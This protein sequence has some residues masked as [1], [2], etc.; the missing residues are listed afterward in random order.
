MNPPV[1]QTHVSGRRNFSQ[2]TGLAC[3]RVRMCVAFAAIAAI[4][5][6]CSEGNPQGDAATVATPDAGPADAATLK[7]AAPTFTPP[8]GAYATAQ[9]V[10]LATSTPG[11][12]VYFTVD[13]NPP[14]TGSEKYTTP[15]SVP[16]SATPVRISA[17]AVAGGYLD[18]DVSAAT[19][20][21]AVEEARAAK[22]SISPAGGSYTSSQLITITTTEPAGTLLFTTNGTLPTKT[23]GT[24]YTGVFTVSAADSTVTAVTTASNK[25]D[26]LPATAT[27]KI[28][29]AV[30]STAAPS[31][32]PAAGEYTEAQSITMSTASADATI[33]YTVDGNSPACDAAQPIDQMCRGTSVRYINTTPPALDAVKTVKALACKFGSTNSTTTSATYTF[34]AAQPTVTASGIVAF[35]TTVFAHV[36]TPGAVLLYTL[37]TDG[38]TPADPDVAVAGTC[39]PASGVA[40]AGSLPWNIG[41]ALD[42]GITTTGMRRNA[43]FKFRACRVG[44]SASAVVSADYSA[45]LTAKLAAPT[46]ANPPYGTANSTVTPVYD[47]TQTGATTLGADPTVGLVCYTGDGVS[48]PACNATKTA[49]AIG[50]SAVYGG[51][52]VHTGA[53]IANN[54]GARNMRAIACK[55]GATDS[56]VLSGTYAFQLRVAAGLESGTVQSIDA[57]L[58]I[59]L[60]V[61]ETPPSVNWPNPFTV[62]FYYTTDGST[63]LRPPTCGDAATAPTLRTAGVAGQANTA[64]F[65][66]TAS[67]STLK[68]IACAAN[69][70]DS[71][72]TTF[73]YSAP[74]QL[75]APAISPAS[76]TYGHAMDTARAPDLPSGTVPVAPK[77]PKV[78]FA[79]TDVAY[80]HV[81]WTD[82]GSDPECAVATNSCATGASLN[83]ATEAGTAVTSNFGGNPRVIKARTCRPGY[84]QSP[85]ATATYIFQIATPALPAGPALPFGNNYQNNIA[86]N[87]Q[88]GAYVDAT[89]RG[90]IIYN[91]ATTAAGTATFALTDGATSAS[92]PVCGVSPTSLNVTSVPRVVKARACGTGFA[93]SNIA[94]AT[95]TTASVAQPSFSLL[96][97]ATYASPDKNAGGKYHDYFDISIASTTTESAAAAAGVGICYTTDG[98]APACGSFSS[99]NLSCSNGAPIDA[100]AA[101]M[102][103]ATISPNP[104]SGT[105]TVRAVACSSGLNNNVSTERSASYAYVVSALN[106]TA[107]DTGAA[108]NKSRAIA[109]SNDATVT[110]NAGRTQDTGLVL[111][112]SQVATPPLGCTA[113][114]AGA[115]HYCF[116]ARAAGTGVDP[117]YTAWATR[118]GTVYLRAC[119]AGL[120]DATATYTATGIGTYSRTVTDVTATGAA[121][122]Y[123]NAENRFVLATAAADNAQAWVSFDSANLYLTTKALPAAGDNAFNQPTEYGYWYLSGAAPFATAAAAS[124][125]GIPADLPAAAL[126]LVSSAAHGFGSAK[127]VVWYNGND[128]QRGMAQ[129][130]GTGWTVVNGAVFANVASSTGFATIPRSTI[131]SPALLTI[132]GGITGGDMASASNFVPGVGNNSA[133][134]RLVLDLAAG[135]H[136][137]WDKHVCDS[138]PNAG[139]SAWV[140]NDG[141]FVFCL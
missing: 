97:R 60:R 40:A 107:A 56:D 51:G 80:N 110:P 74:G 55:P 64:G 37:K 88:F 139:T 113:A 7:A 21:F 28:T 43:K 70:A 31:F 109:L 138:T 125:G 47:G 23:N 132:L 5:A 24:V 134:R 121:G 39:T 22:P 57:S 104:T 122:Q 4:A 50:A 111:C 131:G 99:A 94:T 79:R 18:S 120:E 102:P 52:Q 106:T 128:S 36:T 76:G 13:G 3:L 25:A 89:H 119:K 29:T 14:T 12:T 130:N 98:T 53:S 20:T 72:S 1:N 116:T 19:Y 27:Y 117:Q 78:Y 87:N 73:T 58:T 90:A 115:N 123:S 34:R 15:I 84:P 126:P 66:H 112:G 83:T 136:P 77:Q 86:G 45:K 38:T 8:G 26:S 93:D 75:T 41:K 48:T 42:P 133:D 10:A 68:A 137:A 127:Y 30:G 81:C 96:A 129:W 82:N 118:S 33:C 9:T 100:A 105:L 32:S 11:A 91:S 46:S 67:G 63:P 140:A 69:F 35:D 92:D 114:V 49:C 44:Y 71:P 85:I 61:L 59:A 95:Y 124:G 16:V 17:V 54:A 65:N 141:P 6:G 108:G 2:A 62:D 103:A 101:S 135:T